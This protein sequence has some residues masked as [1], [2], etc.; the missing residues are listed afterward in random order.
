MNKSTRYNFIAKNDIQLCKKLIDRQFNYEVCK[1]TYK[2]PETCLDSN[3]IPKAKPNTKFLAFSTYW[4]LVQKLD[5]K[6]NAEKK[7]YGDRI[8]S[9]NFKSAAEALCMEKTETH[10]LLKYGQGESVGWTLGYVLEEAKKI[11]SSKITHET[12]SR[13]NTCF[14][15]LVC[16]VPVGIIATVSVFT[17]IIRKCIRRYNDYQPINEE[18]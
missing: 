1:T 10:S 3:I 15:I 18:R 14:W 6:L 4:Y 11:K 5:E 7:R 12:S 9:G 16:I 13:S 2:D 8:R 17:C